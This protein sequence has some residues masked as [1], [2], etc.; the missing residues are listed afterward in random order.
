MRRD[1]AG[2]MNNIAPARDDASR[3]R[4]TRHGLAPLF[5]PKLTRSARAELRVRER[6]PW[7]TKWF[8][9][10]RQNLCHRGTTPFGRP[11]TSPKARG[12]ARRTQVRDSQPHHK[13]YKNVIK[14]AITSGQNV[15]L[16]G[17]RWRFCRR[18]SKGTDVP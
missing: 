12:N 5:Q 1:E 15:T 8:A 2:L 6:F 7:L 3:E 17:S 11:G 14:T 18:K 9:V 4:C 10:F 13:E 16:F